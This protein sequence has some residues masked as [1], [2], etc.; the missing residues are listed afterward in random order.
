MVRKIITL[1]VAG[2]GVWMILFYSPAASQTALAV[3]GGNKTAAAEGRKLF[4]RYCASCHG[5][6]GK[7]NGPVAPSLKT[8]PAD[9]TN[10]KKVDGKFPGIRVQ[11]FISGEMDVPAHG[12]REM[13]VWGEVLRR[14]HGEGFAKLEIYNLAKYIESIQGK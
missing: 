3:Q 8:A 6:E 1:A 4:L 7:G 14:K 11:Q 5:L 13:P 2:F 10:I 9:L 12:T